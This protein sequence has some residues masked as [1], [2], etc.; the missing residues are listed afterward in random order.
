VSAPSKSRRTRSVPIPS[1][2]PAGD[3]LWYRDAVFYELRVGA[4][5]DSDGDGV[6]DFRGL[7]ERLDYLRDL[8]VTTLWLLPFYPSPGRDDGY[9]IADYS[10]IH[11]QLGTLDDFREFLREAHKRELRVVTELVINH[12]SDQHPWFQRA[13]RSPPGSKYRDY[14]VWS[15]TP[16]R[17]PEA[18]IIFKDFEPSNWSWDPV[19]KAYYWHRFFSHQPDLNFDN[20]AVQK[21]VFAAM[22]FWFGMGVDGLRLDAIPYLYERDGT[23][24]ENLPETHAFLKRLRKH[25]DERHQDRMLLAEANQWP[26]DAVTYF[27]NGDECHMAF[28]FPVMP[29]LFM[30]LHME[31]R[32]PIVDILAQTPDIPQNTQW[33]MFLRN[34]DELTLEMVTDEE[35]DYMYRVYA[36]DAQARIN[37]GI[38]R[39]LA[40]LVGNDRRRIEL[41]NALLFSLPGTP[42]V[43]YGDE[44][45][46]GDNFYLGDRNGVRTPMQWSGDRNAGFSRCN[47]QR[48]YL[49]VIVDPEYHYESRNVEAQQTNQHSL[50]W[51]MKR[52][53]ALR[54][55][56][57]AFGRGSIAFLYPSNPKV[58]AFT[59]HYEGDTI[60]VVANL[61][62]FVQYVE[63]DLAQWKGMVAVELFGRTAFPPIGDLPYLLTLGPHA[64]YWFE[65][66]PRAE[67]TTTAAVQE[68]RPARLEVRGTWD[69][70]LQDPEF[71]AALPALLRTRRWFGGKALTIK[72]TAVADV[73]QIEHEDRTFVL[74]MIRVDYVQAESQTYLWP[75]AFSSGD[76][77]NALRASAPKSIVAELTVRDRAGAAVEGIVH[78]AMEDPSVGAVLLDIVGRRRQLK[79]ATGTLAGVTTR[80]FR[81]LRGD[82]DVALPATVLRAEQSNTSVAYGD[83]LILKL[84][85]RLAE[86]VNPDMEVGRFLTERTRFT[87]IAPL[88][89]ALELRRRKGE[90]VTVALL[91]GYVANATDAWEYT[92]DQIR[93]YY[94]RALAKRGELRV[95]VPDRSLLELTT[96][97][98]PPLVAET[99]GAY[100]EFARLLGLRTAELHQALASHADDPAFAPEAF[101][102]LYQRGLYQSWRNLT[103]GVLR[104][105]NDRLSALPADV[106][107]DAKRL[108][109]MEKQLLNRFHAVLGQTIPAMRIRSHGDYHLGQ[110]LWTGK[111]FVIIDFEGEPARPLSERRTKRAALR[112]VAGMLRSFDYAAQTVLRGGAVR[113]QDRRALEP[114]SR[115]W[116]LWTSSAFLRAYLQQMEGS[117]LLPRPREQVARLLD[118]LL[119]EKIVYELGYELNN[120][121]EWV[122][123]PLRGILRTL[124]G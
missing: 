101:T 13:R 39:R 11:P 76:A 119:L 12:T 80:A 25:V 18:R 85:R 54:K 90:P 28:H 5:S 89:G 31:D 74:A 33:A 8:G 105:L 113:P 34:H 2:A 96:E 9:D 27:G 115:F 53:I 50:L 52:L 73:I 95:V 110:V 48:L 109:G 77:A 65:L 22:D 98:P 36:H 111:D 10:D 23:N 55:R 40:P 42:V 78:G 121:P 29:R 32:F 7:T 38:R 21:A 123:I 117:P 72:N 97:D 118:V 3:P 67:G 108:A 93:H 17:W 122:Q 104:V 58:L 15:D 37:L 43:Y 112:D 92:Q 84:F 99:L 81:A 69:D 30:A 57:P 46:M 87:H 14:Y 64:F 41:M 71:A 100:I 103:A 68:A 114:W 75:L 106:R 94:D 63:L 44:I 56:H 59:R 86:G 120:R 116:T 102:T 6:G 49:P 66:E 26:E 16:E 62:R 83:R 60:L 79:G 124:G 51:W 107:D 24:C 45:G 70:V 82:P 4:F 19:A 20:P 1:D 35:R 91:Q 88:A 61:S 47:P